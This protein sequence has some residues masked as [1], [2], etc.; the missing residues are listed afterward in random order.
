MKLYIVGL[1][2]LV[3]FLASADVAL[4][5]TCDLPTF[6]TLKQQVRSAKKR[7]NAIFVGKI[8]EIRFSEK[9]LGDKAVSRYA[10]F[11]VERSWSGP[12]TKFIEIETA[13]ICCIC[14]ITFEVGERWIVYAYGNVKKGYSTNSCSRTSP[15]GPKSDDEKYLGRKRLVKKTP[16]T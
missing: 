12:E 16:K 10:K 3:L 15:I 9:K 7:S 1:I 4:A 11:E 8:V 5:C 14:G 6:G 13:N 2:G